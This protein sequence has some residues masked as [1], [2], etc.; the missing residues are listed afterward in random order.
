MDSRGKHCHCES[1]RLISGWDNKEMGRDSVAFWK[2]LGE[3]RGD[4]VSIEILMLT[5]TKLKI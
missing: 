1:F 2:N 5:M 4:F 3:I